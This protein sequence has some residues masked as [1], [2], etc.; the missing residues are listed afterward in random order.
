[1]DIITNI[2][3]GFLAQGLDFLSYNKYNLSNA[4][5]AVQ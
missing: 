5:V 1:M 3:S 4:E 2:L